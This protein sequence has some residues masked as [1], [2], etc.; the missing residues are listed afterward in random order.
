MARDIHGKCHMP[1]RVGTPAVTSREEVVMRAFTALRAPRSDGWFYAAEIEEAIASELGRS[2][3]ESTVREIWRL[4]RKS[5]K[6][7]AYLSTRVSSS[8]DRDRIQYFLRFVD[9]KVRVPWRQWSQ[10]SKEEQQKLFP[11]SPQTEAEMKKAR[12][13]GMKVVAEGFKVAKGLFL[14]GTPTEDLER[15]LLKRLNPEPEENWSDFAK[16]NRERHLRYLAKVKRPP[17]HEFATRLLELLTGS[18]RSIVSHPTGT[19]TPTPGP[20]NRLR[21]KKERPVEPVSPQ[22]PASGRSR[23]ARRGTSR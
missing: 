21:R 22:A 15:E 19:R 18:G 7:R 4:G 10:L 13:Q 8:G 11:R 5:L 2:R 23:Q 6:D 20:A 1:R 14:G 17:S 3:N 9:G 12:S 16:R